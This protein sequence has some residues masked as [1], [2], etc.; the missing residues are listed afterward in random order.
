MDEFIP[1]MPDFF[2]DGQ[3]TRLT[4]RE[5]CLVGRD[6]QEANKQSHICYAHNWN[7]CV[8]SWLGLEV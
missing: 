2:V 8:R 5:Q 6:Q 7:L 4:L 3:V 1:Q